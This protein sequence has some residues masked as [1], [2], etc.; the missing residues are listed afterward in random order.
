MHILITGGSG[1]IGQALTHSF[2]SEGHRVSW[3]SRTTKTRI[4]ER[5]HSYR[6]SF[7]IIPWLYAGAEPEK[8]LMQTGV[9]DIVIHLAGTSINASRWSKAHKEAILTSRITTTETLLDI[10]QKLPYLPTLYIN[11]SA[12]EASRPLPHPVN[13]ESPLSELIE[14]GKHFYGLDYLT[15]VTRV[16]EGRANRAKALGMRTVYARFG[17]V[18]SREGGALPELVRPVRLYAGGPIA[19]GRQVLSWVHIADVVGMLRWA[20]DHESIQGP[21]HIAAP[22]PATNAHVTQTIARLLKRPY[23]F[24]I[25]KAALKLI[26]GE[27]SALVTEGYEQKPVEALALGYPFHFPTLETA[28]EDLLIHK[29]EKEG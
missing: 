22:E 5:F 19:G 21:L 15:F 10:L 18:F 20:I 13:V 23:W 11:A 26:L 4:P 1:L 7:Q 27:M 17:I 9:P 28:L 16:W 12:L 25:P 3:L 14:T 29:H 8:T 2:L 6:N 24:P